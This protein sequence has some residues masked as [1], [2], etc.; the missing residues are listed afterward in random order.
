MN[1]TLRRTRLLAR[2]PGDLVGWA[3]EG[4][5]G[6]RAARRARLRT[7]LIALGMPTDGD[8]SELVGATASALATGRTDE[9]WLAMAVLTA[10]MPDHLAVI[11]AVR[12]ARLDGPLAALDEALHSGAMRL[13]RQHSPELEHCEVEVITGQVVVDVNNTAKSE[14]ATGI[15]RVARE[16]ARR[17]HRDHHPLFVGWHQ[18]RP[19]LLRLLPPELRRALYG[20]EPGELPERRGRAVLVPWRCEYVLPELI[21]ELDRVGALHALFRFSGNP[22]AAIGF[23]CVPLTVPETVAAEP[24]VIGFAAKLASLAHVGRLATISGGAAREYGGWRSMLAGTGLPGPEI[25][26]IPLPVYSE[27]PTL[28]AIEAARRDFLIAGMPMVLVVGS[29]EPRKNHLAILQAA[30]LLWRD[31][32]RFS[33]LFLGGNAWNSGRFQHRLQAL[34]TAGR[35]VDMLTAVSDEQLW[36]AYRIARCSVFPS[37]NEGFG[38]PVAESLASGTPVV[39]SNFGSMH[40]IAQYGGALLVDPRNDHDIANA[41][42]KLILD[43]DLHSALADQ[44]RERPTRTWDEYAYE[45]WAYLVDGDRAFEPADAR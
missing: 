26:T 31:K 39:T 35:P 4:P 18:D 6:V 5:A 38:L 10:T 11:R 16:T 13:Y 42:R 25:S 44:A 45:T 23:D 34:Q 37:L 19:A 17:W 21:A 3:N 1:L 7:L 15:Q 28:A 20:I 36:A 2:E 12:T 9:L 24:V 32:V 14:F 43:D 41:M 30:E 8:T 40:E 33:L 27:P 22:S 29:H